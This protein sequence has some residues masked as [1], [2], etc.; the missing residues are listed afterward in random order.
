MMV[1][2]QYG[3]VV[4]HLQPSH[5]RELPVLERSVTDLRRFEQ[6]FERALDY[7]D[8]AHQRLL[9]AEQI[10]LDRLPSLERCLRRTFTLSSLSIDGGRRRMEGAF[11]APEPRAIVAAMRRDAKTVIHLRDVTDRIW[12]MSRYKRTFRSDGVAL[13]K[14]RRSVF[15]RAEEPEARLAAQGQGRDIQSK[16]RVDCDGL[17]RTNLWIVGSINPDSR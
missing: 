12:W 8:A 10:L 11:P 3:H 4:K 9:A 7:R 15:R 1:S 14:C 5:L 16:A 13:C 6:G 2:A 17:L